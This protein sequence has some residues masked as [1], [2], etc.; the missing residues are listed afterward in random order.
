MTMTIPTRP[1]G[2]A[3]N[4]AQNP[5]LVYWEMTQACALAC[6][7]C[8]AEAMPTRHPAE[9]NYLEGRELL[10]QIAGFGAPAPQLVLTG[11]DPL[12]RPDLF[13]LI[14][15]AQSL[16]LSVSITPSATPR[17]TRPVI[18]SLKDHGIRSLGLSLDGATAA[19]HD[20]VRGIDGCFERTMEALRAGT[21]LGIPMQV[22]TLVAAETLADLPQ[23]YELLKAFKVMRWGLFFLVAVGRGRV[24]REISAEQ[25]ETLM[26]WI[27]TTSLVAPFAIKTTEAPWYRRVAL[28]RMR[29]DGMTPQQIRA[30]SMYAGF[31]IRDGNGIV[32]IGSTG[33]VYPAGFLPI[34]VGNVRSN[35]LVALYRTAPLFQGLRR[36]SAFAGKCGACEYRMICGGSRA[37]AYTAS[38]DALASDPLCPYQPDQRGGPQRPVELELAAAP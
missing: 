9:L 30:T 7:H 4:Y 10:R 3:R 21:E 33:S 17:L 36:P 27:Y 31:G 2:A 19:R 1:A 32:F 6:R 12:D 20:A 15:D 18:A 13:D 38:G 8:R 23:I 24:L 28:E 35:H 26:H 11:G 34:E 22:N 29:A 14:D 25:A 16:G 5:L 37:R